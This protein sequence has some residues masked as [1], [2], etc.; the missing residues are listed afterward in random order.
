MVSRQQYATV[1]LY[2]E[3][4]GEQ[5]RL[6]RECRRAFAS[7]FE[8][9]GFRGRMPRLVACGSRNEA[10]RDFCS[11]QKSAD[12]S[13]K[14]A[15]LLVDSEDA[16]LGD[17]QN[18]PWEHLRNRDQW[19]QPETAT[20]EQVHL[21]IQC[22]ESWFLADKEALRRFFGQGFNSNAL[23][24]NSNIERIV[25]SDVLRSLENATRNSQ[26]GSYGKGAHSFK[27][28]EEIDATKVVNA[29]PSAKR[30]ILELDKVLPKA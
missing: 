25:K 26:K 23:P 1:K 6:K 11:S 21:M 5:N 22:M 24:N 20:N 29:S 18:R 14:I 12:R 9:T 15:F 27:I 3:G 8:S 30:M 4:G 16:V 7:F 19:V 13:N 17:L 28:L 2:I 10:F